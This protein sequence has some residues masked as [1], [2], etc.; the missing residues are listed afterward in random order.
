MKKIIQAVKENYYKFRNLN[1]ANALVLLLVISFVHYFQI[2]MNASVHDI[3]RRL[4]YIPILMG[5][6]TKGIKGGIRIAFFS[7]LVYSPHFFI[8]NQYEFNTY[9]NLILEIVMFYFIGILVGYYSER[10]NKN[11]RILREQIEQLESLESETRALIETVPVAVLSTNRYFEINK[12]NDLASKIF[13][14][15]VSKLS[16]KDKL[17]ELGIS[18]RVLNE[19]MFG[20]LD[21]YDIDISIKDNMS[22]K[23]F[24]CS[25]AARFD[26]NKSKIGIVIVMS[27][28]TKIIE[29][30]KQL[31]QADKLS[32]LGLMASGVAHEIRNPLAIIRAIVQQ[33]T[34]DNVIHDTE[35]IEIILEEIDRV[36]R[37]IQDMLVFS[38]PEESQRLLIDLQEVIEYVTHFTKNYAQQNNVEINVS[39]DEKILICVDK[40]KIIQALIN[41]ILNGIQSISL[42]GYIDITTLESENDVEIKISD[43]GCGISEDKI[44]YLFDPFF[45]TKDT[46]TGLGLSTA[47]SIIH[48]HGGKIKVNSTV[49]IGT[50]FIIELPKVE[51]KHEDNSNSR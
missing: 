42:E 9:I 20:N 40:P 25:L 6:S 30:E 19:L 36:N 28:I 43:N 51:E 44:K 16:V 18:E 35:G 29:F 2:V 27:D 8:L 49:G 26:Q 10:Q 23:T 38:K 48:D 13:N 3:Y 41:I 24:A 17:I 34:H 1:Y 39:S 33:L 15:P 5:A 47:Q 45:T 22:T 11:Q 46:G 32:S 31:G 14:N 37:L 50:Q 21:D 4:Y 12:S 7:M